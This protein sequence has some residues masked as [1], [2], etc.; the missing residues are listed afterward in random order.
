MLMTPP[1]VADLRASEL[2][3][4]APPD[5]ELIEFLGDWETKNGEWVDPLAFAETFPESADLIAAD[6]NAKEPEGTKAQPKPDKDSADKN[7]NERSGGE[8]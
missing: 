8:K 5:L 3:D 4:M 2:Q 1:S 6:D 7:L